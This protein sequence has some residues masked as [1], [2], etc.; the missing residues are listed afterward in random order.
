MLSLRVPEP[1]AKGH[2]ASG[3]PFSW[4]IY[5]WIDGHPYGDDLV[6]DERQAADDLA[7]FVVEL[8]RVDPLGAPGGGRKPLREL[9]AATRVAIAS[10]R[11]TIDSD[12]ATAAWA[13]AL[14]APAWDGTPVWIHTDLLR[15]NLLVDGGRL[16]AV[17]D[18]G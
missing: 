13:S 7:Q 1:L 5:R 9:D 15:P 3:Y 14:E 4:A 16:R 17:I 11:I 10:S 2:A 18:F 12:A 8:R 6:H